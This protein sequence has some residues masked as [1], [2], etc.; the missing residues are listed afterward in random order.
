MT[1]GE[2]LTDGV[3]TLV[4]DPDA[5]PRC[6]VCEHALADHDPISLRYCRATQAQAIPRGCICPKA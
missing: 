1:A 3:A 2:Q 4:V 6:V 5:A